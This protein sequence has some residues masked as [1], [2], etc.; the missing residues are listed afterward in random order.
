MEVTVRSLTVAEVMELHPCAYYS[1][2]RVLKLWAGRESLTIADIA[3]LD[4]PVQDRLWCVLSPGVLPDAVL[5]ELHCRIVDEAVEI[6]ERYYPADLRPRHAN[7]V[8]RAMLRGEATAEEWSAARDAAW[9]AAV[10]AARSAAR[11]AAVDA[12]RS[13]ARDA[14]WDAAVDAAWAAAVDAARSAAVDAARDA[15][16][17]AAVDAARSAAR[18]RYLRWAI[19]A[20]E[21]AE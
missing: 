3:E 6:Y 13:A 4:I 7:E 8:R 19:E 2:S 17:S 16:R 14:A 11:S 21:A 18:T 9:A 20:A 1:E 5:G 12:A 15:A 10:D